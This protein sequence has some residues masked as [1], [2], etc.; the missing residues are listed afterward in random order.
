MKNVVDIFGIA[1][2]IRARQANNAVNVV[3]IGRLLNEARPAFVHGE[4]TCWVTREFD[5]S[6]R[7]A[8]RYRAVADMLS[9]WTKC[10]V[11]DLKISPSALYV[12]AR[13]H[14]DVRVEALNAAREG[15]VSRKDVIEMSQ[16]RIIGG[17]EDVPLVEEMSEE[18]LAGDDTLDFPYDESIDVRRREV[19]A[20]LADGLDG[21]LHAATSEFS[22]CE[23][24]A[25]IS[26]SDI[27]RLIEFLHE[28]RTSQGAGTSSV[29]DI[30]DRA[31]RRS[32]GRAA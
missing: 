21:L 18:D 7:H 31:E 16:R 30:A 15:F 22:T 20:K 27:D 24:S 9:N 6:Y 4:F 32:W 19:E 5:F 26:L 17:A 29:A 10:P 28:L 12:L 3:E 14:D 25:A 8:S 11:S 1:D 13:E 2:R 23:L